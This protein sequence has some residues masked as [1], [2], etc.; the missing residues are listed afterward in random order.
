MAMHILRMYQAA[1]PW[2]ETFSFFK[3]SK[4]FKSQVAESFRDYNL[5][6]TNNSWDVSEDFDRGGG[7]G[8]EEGGE[9]DVKLRECPLLGGLTPFT[10]ESPRAKNV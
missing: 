10:L 3:N 5:Y 9:N 6:S 4:V 2:L 7:G 8:G 1:R